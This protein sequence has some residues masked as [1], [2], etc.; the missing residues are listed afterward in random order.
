MFVTLRQMPGTAEE[1]AEAARAIAAGQPSKWGQIT[2][3]PA[4]R[5]A[6]RDWSAV[7][8]YD[9][10]LYEDA[11]GLEN[12][13]NLEPLGA[14]HKINV[15]TR[16]AQYAW[17]RCT[18]EEAQRDERRLRIVG[19]I[20]AKLRRSMRAEPEQWVIPGGQRQHLWEKVKNERSN[21]LIAEK[22]DTHGGRL[23]ACYCDE[24][25]FGFGWRPVETQS[26]E[27]SKALCLWLNSTLA[28]I[29]LL[30]RRSKK[31]TYPTWSTE[32][33]AAVM[34]P[35]HNAATI[36]RLAWIWE[37]LKDEEL[38][39]MRFGA[40]DEVR[41]AIDAAAAGAAG[42]DN[43]LVTEWREKL[44]REPTITGQRAEP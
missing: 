13:P 3:W 34:I 11:M 36:E 21:L 30:N 4:K 15:M 33:W 28:R 8:W 40:T 27:E 12:H 29:Q 24:P 32:H 19:S 22:F 10:S 37:S 2:R 23:T 1:G 14:Q 39:P 43:A 44:A 5:I 31:L 18:E 35:K 17:R 25:M 41:I 16:D 9:P 26:Q 20:S 7:Q 6:E 38:Q 42:L